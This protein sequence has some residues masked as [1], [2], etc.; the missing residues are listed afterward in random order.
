[1]KTGNILKAI[2]EGE[3]ENVEFKRDVADLGKTVAA[4]ANT[5]GGLILVGVDD[6][7]DVVGIR[8]KS[9]LQE[10]S[11]TFASV[12]PPPS[13]SVSAVKIGDK[14][15]GVVEVKKGRHL[16]AHRNVVSIRVGRNNRPLSIH[17]VVERAVE[18]LR[19]FF[20]ELPSAAGFSS[21]DANL[22]R[23]YLER[24]EQVRGVAVL[25]D[26]GRSL[27]LKLG[28]VRK[29][30]GK[31]GETVTNGGFLFFGRSPQTLIPVARVHLVVFSDE[32]MQHYTD[33]RIFEG[34]LWRIAEEIEEYFRKTLP[35]PGGTLVGFKRLEK[36][37]YPIEA[38]REALLNA[39]VHRNYFDA[40]D[41]KVF[42]LPDRIMIKNPGSFPPGVTPEAPEH[43][44][45]N[46]L[47]ARYF[48]DVGLVEKYGSGIEKIRRVCAEAGVS[49]D[50]ELTATSTTVV[51]RKGKKDFSPDKIDTII[52]KRMDS[53]PAGAT[54]MAGIVKMTR[55]AVNKRLR[56]LIK[57][58]VVE[59]G[60]TGARV[61]YRK[62][63]L[64]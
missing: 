51:F 57:A 38:L 37:E 4:F 24:R 29:S 60:G 36:F 5:S 64:V 62:T 8:G 2:R 52:L 43:R 25:P 48:Y 40:G 17:E 45:R 22:V 47:L 26:S 41:V 31:R 59:R 13:V 55:Q 53:G 58:Q 12:T 9:V 28:I 39:M 34:S 11:D 46:P 44:P 16:Y 21:I 20:D 6:Q 15:V 42:F 3:G 61:L 49:V 23:V 7:G 35:R 27:F 50:F 33:Q 56:A 32:D 18:S 10:I 30:N 14:T 1:M 54:E 19:L 63:K